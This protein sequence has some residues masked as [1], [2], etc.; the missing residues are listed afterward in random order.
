MA[1]QFE[2]VYTGAWD[3]EAYNK[4]CMWAF[5]FMAECEA[6]GSDPDWAA[7]NS[8]NVQA[9]IDYF[10]IGILQWMGPAAGHLLE[11]LYEYSKLRRVD[12]EGNYSPLNPES[13]AMWSEIP[14]RWSSMVE[15][16]NYAGF[17]DLDFPT[18]EA[19]QWR[20]AVRNHLEEAKS[21]QMG[22]WSGQL[23]EGETWAGYLYLGGYDNASCFAYYGMKFSH[24]KTL[25]YYM[26]LWHLGPAYAVNLWNKCGD[27]DDLDVLCDTTI[28]ILSGIPNWGAFREG[29]TNRYAKGGIAYKL[30][31]AWDGTSGAP[32]GEWGGVGADS[33]GNQLG[34]ADPV[35]GGVNSGR[36][37]IKQI[38][39]N[40][41]DLFVV[42]AQGEMV[43]CHR[44]EGGNV[45][46]PFGRGSVT[47]PSAYGTPG[48]SDYGSGDYDVPDKGWAHAQEAYD[49]LHAALGQWTYD[50][51]FHVTDPW[52]S[53][54]SDCSGTVWWTIYHFDQACANHYRMVGGD[55]GYT[56]TFYENSAASIQEGTSGSPDES[57]MKPG[58]IVLMNFNAPYYTS[59]GGHS[60]M[61]VGMYFGNNIFIHTNGTP[62]PTETTLSGVC[63]AAQWWAVK[64]PP[65]TDT[66]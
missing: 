3:W 22:Y 61:H 21:F 55:P 35:L 24:I 11:Q 38:Y 56:G 33:N 51:D 37:R 28:G 54:K 46:I 60:G 31:Q 66:I 12:E 34:M 36:D 43:M 40:G 45:W 53:G 6:G 5:Y 15:S 17:Y 58:D 20:N 13:V 42:T 63:S 26:G 50:Q 41:Q 27:T 1:Y 18:S 47:N 62:D 16:G 8:Y 52:V 9:G 10:T 29:W 49:K 4:W 64:R 57:L 39:T 59:L 23:H 44:A 65:Y 19:N 25:M 30:L 7:E 32:K 14:S 2:D 48:G